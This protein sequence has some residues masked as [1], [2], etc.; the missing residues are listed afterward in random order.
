[1][2]GGATGIREF[3]RHIRLLPSA[4]LRVLCAFAYLR[5]LCASALKIH[6]AIEG[7]RVF[8]AK[9]QSTSRYAEKMPS[10]RL[11]RNHSP[12]YVEFRHRHR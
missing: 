2:E 8:N 4:Y 10:A 11:F 1:M 7:M 3:F 12:E 5:V 6:S 9:A